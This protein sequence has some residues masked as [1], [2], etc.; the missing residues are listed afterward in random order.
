MSSS[1]LLMMTLQLRPSRCYRFMRLVVFVTSSL[2]LSRRSFR[3]PAPSST[4]SA[5]PNATEATAE[6]SIPSLVGFSIPLPD[7]TDCRFAL[8]RGAA[9]IGSRSPTWEGR[10]AGSTRPCP[11]YGEAFD[12]E[13]HRS[14]RRF[15]QRLLHRP[16]LAAGRAEPAPSA[17][18]REGVPR[19]RGSLDDAQSTSRHEG[20]VATELVYERRVGARHQWEATLPFGASSSETEPLERGIGDIGLGWKSAFWHTAALHPHRGRRGRSFLPGRRESRARDGHR[21][22]RAV[23]RFRAVAA[24]GVVPSGAGRSGASRG[25]RR[26]PSGSSSG[27]ARSD[28]ASRR[29]R[30]RAHVVTRC[31]SSRKRGLPTSTRRAGASCLRCK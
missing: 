24:A 16:S 10:R 4:R 17:R 21:D 26:R 19:R 3:K 1:D 6:V 5:A 12:A 27:E 23:P 25:F 29:R 11:S 22:L 20:A 30:L 14:D 18:D 7:F 15:M 31:S 8:A 2:C 9:T 13:A 28:A